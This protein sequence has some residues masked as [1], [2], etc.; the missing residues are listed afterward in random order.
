[1][2]S[3]TVEDAIGGVKLL[4]SEDGELVATLRA[5]KVLNEWRIRQLSIVEARRGDDLLAESL[6]PEIIAKVIELGWITED[7]LPDY[8]YTE[9]G[10]EVGKLV[11]ELPEQKHKDAALR[12][13]TIARD[14]VEKAAVKNNKVI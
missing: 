1:M 6:Y 12:F 14:E 4:V 8:K 3:I 10:I 2:I 7:E 5:M 9:R 11:V 13:R